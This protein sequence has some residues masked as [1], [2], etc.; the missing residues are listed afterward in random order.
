[1]VGF[2]QTLCWIDVTMDS[3]QGY[4]E[5]LCKMMSCLRYP[6][7][8]V[9]RAKKY[10]FSDWDKW[11]A[12]VRIQPH[13]TTEPEYLFRSHYYHDSMESAVQDAAREAF[14]RLYAEHKEELKRT[15]FTHHP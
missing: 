8:L 13:T 7:A 2:G 14:L 11:E 4:D 9:Y 1:M 10:D 15:E 3:P 12:T 6:I 5:H